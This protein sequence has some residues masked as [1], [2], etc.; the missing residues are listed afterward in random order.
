MIPPKLRGIVETWIYVEAALFVIAEIV[1]ASVFRL[2]YVD[3]PRI[4]PAAIIEAVCAL[5]LV[6][7]AREVRK[8]GLSARRAALAAQ[9]VAIGAVGLG[10]FAMSIGLAP[11]SALSLAYYRGLLAVL[12]A[13]FFVLASPL[14]RARTERESSD[15]TWSV[16][17]TARS[18]RG[19]ARMA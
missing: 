17:R 11:E 5:M 12:V 6:A 7:V 8:D 9:G 18:A 15:V 19:D 4:V 14:G 2:P 10:M 16:M 3:E 13:V 1:H